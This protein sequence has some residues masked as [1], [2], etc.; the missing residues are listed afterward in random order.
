MN[1][2]NSL[3]QII[4]YHFVDDFQEIKDLVQS[5]VEEGSHNQVVAA[6][7]THQFVKDVNLKVVFRLRDRSSNSTASK[8]LR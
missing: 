3:L 4:N 8:D 5:S 7:R 2:L 1:V 6:S